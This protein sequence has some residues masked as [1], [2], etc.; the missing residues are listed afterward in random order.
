MYESMTEKISPETR[1]RMM[2]G[3]RASNTKP[4]KQVRSGLHANGFRF[5]LHEHSLPG[6]PDIVLKRWRVAVFV[7]G[8]F[9]HGHEG[10]SYFRV[11]KTRTDFWVNKIA[12]NAKRDARAI[13]ILRDRGWRVAV[14]W[15]C[16]L[17]AD[18]ARAVTML[19]EFIRSEAGFAE[20]ARIQ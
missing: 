11:P 4:E 9:W 13:E 18:G 6:S 10:C 7:H 8:C 20:I 17:R 16:A 2:S 5:R 12:G 15:E 19:S 1:S 3:I 14:V